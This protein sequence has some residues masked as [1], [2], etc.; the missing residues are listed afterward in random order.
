MA[1]EPTVEGDAKELEDLAGR[2]QAGLDS[3]CQKYA[4][5]GM[6]GAYVLPEG[7]ALAFASGLADKE[8]GTKMAVDSRMPAGSIGKMFVGA[9]VLGLAQDGKLSLDDKIEKWLGAEDWFDDLPNAHEMTIRHLLMHRGG[10]ADHIYDPQWI[11]A[12]R[13][14]VSALDTDPDYYFKP[15]ELVSY[16]LNREPLFA[17]GEGFQYTDTG[18][19][20]LGLI[21]ERAGGAS[22]YQQIEERFLKP[23][24]LTLTTP[25]NR[26]EIAKLASGYVSAEN[27][28]GLPEKMTVEGKLCYNPA[29]EWTGGGLISNPQDLVRWA[30]AYFES[31][32]LDEP[33]LEELLAAVP[34][35]AEKS[36]RYGLGVYVKKDDLGTSYGHGGWSVGYLSYVAYYPAQQVAVAV[37]VNT[38]VND[39]LLGDVLRLIGD[40]LRTVE[41]AAAE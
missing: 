33:Y 13:R 37:Q 32:V 10:I 38:D 31:Q 5:P 29:T 25:A 2:F 12:A 6:T 18:Y 30:K 23:W 27:P 16:V 20:L 17:V 39:N 1:K 7:T 19:I 11:E 28:F 34:E 9:V 8:S 3:I 26:R 21:I 41:K 35:E 14:M 15:R 40:V 22:Y 24:Q 36:S 4:L